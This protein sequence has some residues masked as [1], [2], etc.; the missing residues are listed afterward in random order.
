M[1]LSP[2]TIRVLENF[3]DIN[4]SMLLLK[5]K[6]QRTMTPSKTIFAQVELEDE[7]PR[8][9]GIYNLSTLIA[10]FSV[11][12][13]PEF[14]FEEN[15]IEIKDGKSIGK[16]LYCA[17]ELIKHPAKD[18]DIK[19][20]TPDIAFELQESVLDSLLKG[21]R[22][23]TVPHFVIEGDGQEIKIVVKNVDNKASDTFAKVVGETKE[24]FSMIL[25]ISTMKLLI[26]DY[27]VSI[28]KKGLVK[29]K[30]KVMNLSY[31]IPV[32]ST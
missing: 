8:E 24:N 29:M 11:F 13:K 27:D 4:N 12:D 20:D 18:K 10:L 26:N 7:I 16:Y 15:H 17:P 28:S 23:L 1:K 19:L 3:S 21:A 6:V 14:E 22:I 30:S 31:F 9:F 5:G 32:Q 25:D 2:S